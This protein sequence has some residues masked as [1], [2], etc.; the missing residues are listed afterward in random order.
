M[1]LIY[2]VTQE[3]HQI[4]VNINQAFIDGEFDHFEDPLGER[5]RLIA[6]YLVTRLDKHNETTPQEAHQTLPTV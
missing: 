4:I 3:L 6:T 5:D 1:K 2:E